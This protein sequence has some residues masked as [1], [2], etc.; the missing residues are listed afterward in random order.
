MVEYTQEDTQAHLKGLENVSDVI[1]QI[2]NGEF[3]VGNMESQSLTKTIKRQTD[4]I[5]L[6]LDKEHIQN[7]GADLTSFQKALD[8]GLAWISANAIDL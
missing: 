8:D 1:Y 7:S 2:I 4:H 5:S 3:V 6:M